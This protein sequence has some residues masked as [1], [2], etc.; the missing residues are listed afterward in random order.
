[1]NNL[2]HHFDAAYVINLD[3]RQ[4]R[5]E[6]FEQDQK[7]NWRVPKDFVKRWQAFDNPTNCHA[8]CTRSHRMLLRHIASSG[9]D[10]VLVMEDDCAAITKPILERA[11][12]YP[13]GKVWDTF[14]KINNGLGS[15]NERFS[16]LIPHVPEYDVLYLGGGYGEPPIS[17]VNEFVIR[18]GFMQTTSSYGISREFAEKWSNL[19]DAHGGLDHHPGPIDNLFGSFAKDHRYYVLQPR[20]TFQ[21]ESY[22]DITGQ[23][24]GYLDSMTNPLHENMV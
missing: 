9:Y 8:G 15:V 20:L 12:H 16:E 2:E 1:M 7:S 21:R 3:R 13:G 18:C 22:S 11:G 17:R 14:C 19:V 5:L 6:Q 4:D 23:V 24:N 10:R